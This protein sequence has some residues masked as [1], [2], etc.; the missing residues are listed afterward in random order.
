MAR[1]TRY[2]INGVDLL[3][4]LENWDSLMNFRVR[5]IACGGTALTLLNIKEST[6]DIDLIVP[7]TSEYDKLMKFLKALNYRYN[8]NGL[9]HEDDPNFIY[10]FWCGNKVFTTDLLE[11][12]LKEHN[13]ILIKRWAHIYLGALNLTDLIITKMFRGTPADREDCLAAFATGQVD[14][15]KLFESYSEAARYDLNPEKVMQ[16]FGYLAEGLHEG[17]LISEKFYQKVR[18]RL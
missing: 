1:L 10:Q 16:N 14:A 5:L 18:S 12:P 8:G 9:V 11:S 2:R 6:K 17:Q 15:E 13:H 3:D 7:E 4:T